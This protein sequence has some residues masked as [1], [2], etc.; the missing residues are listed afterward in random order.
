[1]AHLRTSANNPLQIAEL[2]VSDGLIGITFAP[3]KYQDDGLTGRHSRDLAADLDRIAGWNA[4]VVVTLVEAEE[5]DALG[6]MGLGA[7][8]R[9]RHMAW[10]HWPIQD[11][12]VP[13]AAFEAAWPVRSAQ[14][15]SLAGLRRPGSHPIARAAWAGPA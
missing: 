5:L 1:M 11:Y 3:G 6:I 7:E 15:R 10:R 12:Q 14:L 9:R 13:D 2:R 4:A 8:V